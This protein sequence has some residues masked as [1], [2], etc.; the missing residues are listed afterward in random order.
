MGEM[1]AGYTDIE[2][3][4]YGTH[5]PEVL[6]HLHIGRLDTRLTGRQLAFHFLAREQRGEGLFQQLLETCLETGARTA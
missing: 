3:I 1:T 6:H 5:I 4:G 2:P